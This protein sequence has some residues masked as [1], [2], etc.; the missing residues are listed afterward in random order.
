MLEV[1]ESEIEI[2]PSHSKYFACENFLGENFIKYNNNAGYVLQ[3]GINKSAII[4]D[5][6]K[7]SNAFSHWTLDF[8]NAKM[9]VIDMQGCNN[10]MTDP[11][12]HSSQ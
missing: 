12:M 8:S 5:M 11:A 10:I 6:Q 7:V 3:K 4:K 9:I 1:E 2:H